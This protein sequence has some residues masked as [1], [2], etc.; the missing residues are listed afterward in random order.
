MYGRPAG[1]EAGRDPAEGARVW[2]PH[3]GDLDGLAPPRHS[4]G[5][6]LEPGPSRESQNLGGRPSLLHPFQWLSEANT[7]TGGAEGEPRLQLHL[8]SLAWCDSGAGRVGSLDRVPE[9]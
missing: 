4:A 7:E 9:S 2:P 3:P 5:P 8:G 1:Q 6:C